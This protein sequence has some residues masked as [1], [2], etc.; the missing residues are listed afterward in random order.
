MILFINQYWNKCR[1]GGI[2]RG[3]ATTRLTI[4][5]LRVPSGVVNIN[6]NAEVA[7]LVDAHD[8]KSCSFGS[9][10]SILPLGTYKN[11][12][13]KSGVFLLLS[14]QRKSFSTVPHGFR[15]KPSH[16][17][18]LPPKPRTLKKQRNFLF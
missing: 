3:S 16:H 17:S 18:V 2:G 4:R 12:P 9:G 11:T 10:S 6:T 13:Q 1:G 8:S 14:Q 5:C 7:E 15:L